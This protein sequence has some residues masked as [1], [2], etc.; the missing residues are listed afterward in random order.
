VDDG[1][2][3][4]CGALNRDDNRHR[5]TQFPVWCLLEL[6]GNCVVRRD[7]NIGYMMRNARSVKELDYVCSINQTR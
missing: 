1:T 2:G 4:G 5:Y 6:V 7:G 3:S